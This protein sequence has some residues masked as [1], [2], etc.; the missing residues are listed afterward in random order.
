[1]RRP[2]N[3]PVFAAVLPRS[4]FVGKA[5]K[6]HNRRTGGREDRALNEDASD[7]VRLMPS[8]SLHDVVQT[9]GLA[10]HA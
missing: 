4:L 10:A 1:V 5:H 9:I 2:G 7:V 3:E 8:T 6:I